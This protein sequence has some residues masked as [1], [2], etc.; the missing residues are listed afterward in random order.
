MW[1]WHNWGKWSDPTNGIYMPMGENGYARLNVVL[2]VFERKDVITIDLDELQKAKG[3][4]D[5][6]NSVPLEEVV[7]QRDGATVSVPEM[8]S[9]AWK[10]IGL[11]NVYFAYEHMLTPNK[12]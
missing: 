11:T 2:G 8:E 3:L 10:Y 6:A 5:L 7:W 4:I 1:C 12:Y 9:R